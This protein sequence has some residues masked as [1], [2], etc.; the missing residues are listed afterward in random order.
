MGSIRNSVGILRVISRCHGRSLCAL[1]LRLRNLESAKP[2][3]TAG[4]QTVACLGMAAAWRAR[5][6]EVSVRAEVDRLKGDLAHSTRVAVGRLNALT[7][8]QRAVTDAAPTQPKTEDGPCV[9]KG[10]LRKWVCPVLFTA[11]IHEQ[12]KDRDNAEEVKTQYLQSSDNSSHLEIVP[13]EP[14][15]TVTKWRVDCTCPTLSPAHLYED[16]HDPSDDITTLARLFPEVRFSRT[17][18]EVPSDE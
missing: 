13:A 2:E 4:E 9:L 18:V 3:S 5:A 11:T 1:E 16:F 8:L 6:D 12:C 14:P 10:Q 15:K 7:C 17:K